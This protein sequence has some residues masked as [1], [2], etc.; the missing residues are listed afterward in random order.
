MCAWEWVCACV[1][2]SGAKQASICLPLNFRLIF[3]VTNSIQQHHTNTTQNRTHRISI[4]PQ[5]NFAFFSP[6]HRQN[7]QFIHRLPSF[8]LF[9][10]V[11]R[12]FGCICF[13]VCAT[14]TCTYVCMYWPY[15]I[16]KYH[17]YLVF[18][19]VKAY[20]VTLYVRVHNVYS[21]YI[22]NKVNTYINIFEIFSVFCSISF[23]LINHPI[24]NGAFIL[25]I[26]CE[27]M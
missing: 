24:R 13:V 20:I 3:S 18:S 19:V 15:S 21:V 14:H 6:K 4:E 17:R 7:K 16:Y 27:T 26:V 11:F 9:H 25:T 1:C 23:I 2:A 5:L 8:H 12:L 10:I 22:V